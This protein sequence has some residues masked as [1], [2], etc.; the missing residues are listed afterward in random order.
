LQQEYAFFEL[1]P[2]LLVGIM[3]GLLGSLFNHLNMIV[4]TWRKPHSTT[5]R[6]KV[7]N[8]VAISVIT[9]AVTFLLPL[10]VSCRECP[11]GANCP[12][13]ESSYSGNFV[14]FGCSAD[15]QYND[16]ATLFF[17]TQDDAIRNLFSAGTPYEYSMTS[18]LLFFCAFY[19][20][21]VITYGIAVPAGVH[22]SH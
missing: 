11:P 18:L 4:N 22:A 5:I 16:L 2:M 17:N 3:G 13:S 6:G 7:L 15:N 9:A 1:V 10:T 12:R 20:L 8:V 14:S 21:M 19:G